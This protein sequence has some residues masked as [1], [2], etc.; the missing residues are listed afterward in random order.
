MGPS[1]KEL[2]QLEVPNFLNDYS[3]EEIMTI[4]RSGR[5]DHGLV[6]KI[7]YLI[8]ANPTLRKYVQPLAERLSHSYTPPKLDRITKISRLFK[9]PK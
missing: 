2:S 7:A 6:E 9:Q 5:L 1:S 4:V 3:W 8:S